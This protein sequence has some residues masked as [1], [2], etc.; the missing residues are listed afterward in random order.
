[1]QARHRGLKPA[2]VLVTRNG[3]IS[4]QVK[5]IDFGIA[6]ATAVELTDKTLFTGI[7]RPIGTPPYRSPEQ[8]GQSNQNHDTR[9][10]IYS[11][12]VILGQ[13][14]TDTTPDRQPMSMSAELDRIVKKCTEFERDRRY[15][16]AEALALDLE[17]LVKDEAKSASPWRWARTLL[18]RL[19]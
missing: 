7:A 11:L 19:S 18:N 9:S 6:M 1:M 12:G 13:I 5:L 16:T 2:D 3:A 15:P 14:L 17:Q 8:S 4:G 10:D